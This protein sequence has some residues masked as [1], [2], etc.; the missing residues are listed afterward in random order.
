MDWSKYEEGKTIG[1]KGSEDG[2]TIEDLENI[3][4]ARITLER[5]GNIAPYSVTI[6]IYGLMFHTY[7]S[8]SIEKAWKYLEFAK[9]KIDQILKEYDTPEAQ[10]DKNWHDKKNQ[11]IEELA[12]H[13]DGG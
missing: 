8:S 10:R 5:D 11:L 2:V 4:G 6:G 9:S 7:F 1:Q 13:N 12:E 3:Q